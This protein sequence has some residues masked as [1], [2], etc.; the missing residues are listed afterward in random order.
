V[1][2]GW[3]AA[4]EIQRHD[5]FG[6]HDKRLVLVELAGRNHLNESRDATG[7]DFR[8]AI[9]TSLKGL[10][11]HSDDLLIELRHDGLLV[12]TAAGV[13]FRHLSFQEYL[14]SEFLHGDQSG[15]RAKPILR[16]FYSGQ[17]WWRDVLDF[18]VT[19]TS[20]PTSMEEWLIQL[21]VSAAKSLDSV[22]VQSLELDRRLSYLRRVLREAF[23]AYTSRYPEDGVISDSIQ[24]GT[25]MIVQR[26]TLSGVRIE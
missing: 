18:Y 11:P 16:Q 24:R 23:P 17:D 14:A 4:K 8:A 13:R 2:G 9:K 25:Q 19:R 26:R 15:Q 6:I 10:L 22:Y 1:C 3:D 20:N 12:T 5:R 21:A 7:N